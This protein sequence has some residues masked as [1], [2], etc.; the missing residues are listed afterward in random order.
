[1]AGHSKWAN[2]KHRKNAQDAKRSKLFTKLLKEITVAARTGSPEPENNPRLRLAIQNARGANV[3]NENVNRAIKKAIGED[4]SNF[5]ELTYEGYGPNGVAVFVE[6]A[7]DNLNRTVSNIRSYFNKA[8]GNLSKKGSLDHLF[9]QKGEFHIDMPDSMNLEDLE[10]ELI[11]A[12]AE[13]VDE[14]EGQ[15]LVYCAREDF[16]ALQDKLEALS[17]TPREAGLRRI[18]VVRQQVDPDT[19]AKANKLIENL[20]E[21]DDVQQ[22]YHDMEITEE[23]MASIE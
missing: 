2:I 9:N 3:P 6:C 8:N 21:D 11:D 10:L 22:V 5:Q 1:M 17:I 18:P 19:F 23:L 16:G 20:E 13:E 12:G 4:S 7:T 15:L 14:N